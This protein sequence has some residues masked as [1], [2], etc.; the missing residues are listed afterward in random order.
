MKLEIAAEYQESFEVQIVHPLNGVPIEKDGKPFTVELWSPKSDNLRA[1]TDKQ[2][3]RLA[4]RNAKMKRAVVPQGEIRA[5][6]NE[7]LAAAHK[8]W[9]NVPVE[10]DDP[11][12]SKANVI[13]LLEEN[14][15][16][17]DQIADALGDV[18]NFL[19]AT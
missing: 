12:C 17:R 18:K 11:E 9:A 16:Y 5:L 7:R 19:K 10:G 2:A 4:I 13:G 8:A 3:E 1:F 14:D 6:V 15:W